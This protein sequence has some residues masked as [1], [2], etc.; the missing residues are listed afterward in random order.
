MAVYRP[1][2]LGNTEADITPFFGGFVDA[3][4][5]QMNQS[6]QNFNK[7]LIESKNKKFEQAQNLRDGIVSGHF[8]DAM[9]SS[10]EGYVKELA[11][12]PTYSKKYAAKLAEA[13]A[14]LGIKVSKQ[15]K[16]TTEIADI[17]QKWSQDPSKKYYDQNALG[18]R[19]YDQ[20]NGDTE[21]GIEATGINTTTEDLQGALTD[22]K[23]NI[24]N[25][26]DGEVRKTFQSQLGE[27]VS[28]VDRT[29]GL[30]N[31]NSEF[32]KFTKNSDGTKFVT[33]F[34]YDA[35]NKMYVPDFDTTKLPPMGLVELYRGVDGAASTLMDDY[36]NNKH[37]SISDDPD[38][39]INDSARQ[40]YE[41]EFVL[42]EMKK[43]APGGQQKSSSE[44]Q[45]RNRPQDPM[46]GSGRMIEMESR[47]SAVN[48]MLNSV[49]RLKNL[50]PAQ[51]PGGPKNAPFAKVD[52]NGDGNPIQMLDIS[53][54]NQGNY[55]V[56]RSTYK[57]I[58]SGKVTESY[59]KPEKT[60]LSIDPD[61][62][63]RTVYFEATNSDGK[64]EYTIYNDRT[65]T[66]FVQNVT[67][68]IYN[69]QKYYDDWALYNKRMT[70]QSSDGGVN[71]QIKLSDSTPAAQADVIEKQNQA[72]KQAQERGTFDAPE[73]TNSLNTNNRSSIEKALLPVNKF[74]LDTGYE[75]S[76]L[77]DRNG[78]RVT[79][80]KVKF[81]K[82]DQFGT[83]VKNMIN[84][85]GKL[86]YRVI[87]DDGSLGE[88][89]TIDY[90]TKDIV[91]DV[92]GGQGT[93]DLN[94]EK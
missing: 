8:S 11:E 18:A 41:R 26:K 40:T 53:N 87:N 65:A 60:Y 69:S 34:K 85:Y 17:E 86:T 6:I 25:I 74:F 78:K 20:L 42:N 83:Q 71:R 35:Q 31:E 55:N 12:L 84:S 36:V 28:Q 38:A 27:I 56:A 29:G 67:K 30:E 94:A 47:H 2:L 64:K 39:P 51:Y 63:E 15:N 48:D 24:N 1:T 77:T 92:S 80:K 62:G 5:A 79:D 33:G 59:V 23:R 88:E 50:D 14:D 90:N 4:A 16:I 72:E 70:Y 46:A 37:R 7:V 9:A 21:L 91:G 89:Q 13:N 76:G 49:D 3:G 58:Q 44:T 22:Y 52:I 54:S 81:V 32:V 93:F 82:F 43:L 45:Y 66:Q 61:D 19:M 73:L 68:G 10:V 75:Q 57:N